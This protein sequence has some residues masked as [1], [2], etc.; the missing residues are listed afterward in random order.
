MC[1]F[2]RQRLRTGLEIC[3]LFKK[4]RDTKRNRAKVILTSEAGRT[5]TSNPKVAGIVKQMNME[6]HR[7]RARP[8]RFFEL[9]TKEQQI[10]PPV[11]IAVQQV[12]IPVLRP[13][14]DL[15]KIC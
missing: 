10:L 9:L 13:A 11:E 5:P 15:I 3:R 7:S 1:E 2:G 12:P 6:Q 4:C 8:N 14:R